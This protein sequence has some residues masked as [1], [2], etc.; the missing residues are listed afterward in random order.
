MRTFVWRAPRVDPAAL[1]DGIAQ[2]FNMGDG[3][4]EVLEVYAEVPSGMSGGITAG[5][6]S[7]SR[8]SALTQG[9]GAAITPVVMDTATGPL[10][11]QVVCVEEPESV[12]V[13]D[14][15]RQVSDCPTMSATVALGTFGALLPLQVSTL[16]SSTRFS[17][18]RSAVQPLVLRE[19]EGIVYAQASAGVPHASAVTLRV[20]DAGSGSTYFF[21]SRDT[22]SRVPGRGL[23]A[24]MNNT[25]SGVVLE[26]NAIYEYEEGQAIV[27][28]VRLALTEGYFE[29]YGDPTF[30]SAVAM[31]T[32]GVLPDTVQLIEGAFLARLPG[33]SRGV[34]YEWYRTHGVGFSIANQQQAGSLRSM[35]RIP[36]VNTPGTNT[37]PVYD[38]GFC[39]FKAHA[40]SG[41]KL[42]SGE[43][44]SLLSGRA[45]VIETSS[46]AFYNVRF[47]FG[48]T[49]RATLNPLRGTVVS[50]A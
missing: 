36:R 48:Y 33:D 6:L 14:L 17:S 37:M 10:P 44:L 21:R 16:S 26:V 12:T 8:I 5:A 2:I 45:G 28:A 31:D 49:P 39:L 22:G 40:G 30:G 46:F 20:R 13:V 34:P 7:V 42:R 38:N 23:F 9:T 24:L 15:L 32:Y 4:V 25:G 35:V 41:I 19:G 43:G 18:G 50:A 27:P 29:G 1:T 11:A 47:V 3:I